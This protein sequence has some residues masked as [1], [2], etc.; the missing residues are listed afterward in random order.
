MLTFLTGTSPS[1]F[2]SAPRL[3]LY[4]LSFWAEEVEVALL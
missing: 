1:P 4:L 3:I 2:F